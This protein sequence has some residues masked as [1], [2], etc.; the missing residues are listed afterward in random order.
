[1][2]KT[3]NRKWISIL[4]CMALV[5]I[6]VFSGAISV[7]AASSTITRGNVSYSHVNG[8][9]SAEPLPATVKTAYT[10]DTLYLNMQVDKSQKV[11]SVTFYAGKG[12][13]TKIGKE[14]ATNYLRYAYKKYTVPNATGTYSY[15]MSIVFT[16]GK[17]TDIIGSFTVNKKA[18]N[19]SDNYSKK[20]SSFIS[21]SRWKNGITWNGSQK[22]KI[23]S[24]SAWGC[25]AYVCD[26]C[27]V[28]FR[29]EQLQ[30]WYEIYESQ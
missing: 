11:K 1:M 4:L 14:T 17:K 15:K 23:S 20:V 9:A 16:N 19:T 6:T 10:G 2:F 29:Q 3:K 13:L 18:N 5:V 22:P 27:K 24:Y 26:F 7:S 12:T 30:R 8:N 21:D 25:C 28:R